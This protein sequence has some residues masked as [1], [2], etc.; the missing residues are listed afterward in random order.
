MIMERDSYCGYCGQAF[1]KD[2]G[3]P[4]PCS[5]CSNIIY[6]NPTP[7]AVV[8]LPVDGGLLLIKR[9][10]AP[11][12]GLWALPGGFVDWGETWQEAAARELFEETHV[13][14]SPHEVRDFLVRSSDA[15]FVVIFG[16]AQP[17]RAIDLPHFT[18]TNE[19]L[20]RSIIW[21]PTPL[22]FDLHTQAAELYFAKRS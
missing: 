7:V 21:E 4:K 19:T 10:I 12:I 9:G 11:Q 14:I 8:L 2:Q 20:E 5:A 3:Y 16:L 15:G 18:P 6:R 1:P 17:R 13:V 22:A